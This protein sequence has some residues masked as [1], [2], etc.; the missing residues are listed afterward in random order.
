[1]FDLIELI[2]QDVERRKIPIVAAIVAPT[3]LAKESI[4]GL[5]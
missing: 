2:R 5:S 3:Q 1:M 4:A